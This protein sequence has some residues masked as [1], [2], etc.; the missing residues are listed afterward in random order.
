L[1]TYL[2]ALR[3]AAQTPLQEHP[4]GRLA[5]WIRWAEAYV[6]DIDPMQAVESLPHDPAGYGRQPID[7][8]GF[9]V[10]ARTDA[11]GADA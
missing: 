2:T 9:G 10:D 6:A 4:D 7:L 3:T 5:R 1:R 8:G 11:P